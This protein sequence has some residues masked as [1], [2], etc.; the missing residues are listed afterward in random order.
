MSTVNGETVL[1]IDIALDED[2]N[3][4]KIEESA[5]LDNADIGFIK[6]YAGTSIPDGYL[7]CDGSAVSRTAY[8]ELFAAIGTVW[9]EGDGSSTF[10]VPDLRGFFLRGVGGNSAAL[11]AEQGDAIRNITGNITKNVSSPSMGMLVGITEMFSMSGALSLVSARLYVPGRDTTRE[12]N[13]VHEINFDASATG[14]PTAAEN[15]PVNKAVNYCI[16]YA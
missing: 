7:L 4:Q 2:N 5:V 14:I 15:R 12:E 3:L 13:S 9:G 6:P 8:P 10:N 11:A 16:R 1:V